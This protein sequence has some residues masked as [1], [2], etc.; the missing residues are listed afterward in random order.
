MAR[1]RLV[2]PLI[3]RVPWVSL[4]VSVSL[5]LESLFCLPFSPLTECLEHIYFYLFSPD[6]NSF[7]S[8]NRQGPR[9]GRLGPASASLAALC[10]WELAA[11][12]LGR[13]PFPVPLHGGFTVALL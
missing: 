4:W 3:N 9:C 13:G 11:S 6:P 1:A 10:L 12:C 7:A 5:H 8:H 2:V